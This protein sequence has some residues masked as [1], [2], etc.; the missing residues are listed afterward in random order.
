MKRVHHLVVVKFKPDTSATTV[1]RLFAALARLKQVIPGIAHY[2]G[3]PYASPEGL[4]QGFTHGFL[5]TFT[6]AAARDT[7]LTHPD[8]EQVKR[9]FLPSIENVIAFDFEEP[10]A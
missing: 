1:S 6:N 7:Y 2:A 5:M 8:H 4:N 9:D 10:V 3:G